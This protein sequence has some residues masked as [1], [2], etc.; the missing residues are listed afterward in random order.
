MWV[1]A[2]FWGDPTV[3]DISRSTSITSGCMSVV[4][5]G[6]S[7]TRS[8]KQ[9]SGGGALRADRQTP[10]Q[11][12]KPVTLA[13]STSDQQQFRGV[14]VLTYATTVL[15]STRSCRA[16]LPLIQV[17]LPSHGPVRRVA[18]SLLACDHW[19][20]RS[21]QQ[22]PNLRRSGEGSPDNYGHTVADLYNASPSWASVYVMFKCSASCT[23]SFW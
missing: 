17:L 19:W 8:V 10:A 20:M 5:Q 15:P 1:S 9:I 6:S 22:F 21:L 18:G 7:G 2:S 16:C 14:N 4:S 11:S 12:T 23:A 13:S 3:L